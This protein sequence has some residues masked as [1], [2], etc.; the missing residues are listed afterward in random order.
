MVPILNCLPQICLI[1]DDRVSKVSNA[2]SATANDMNTQELER[3]M[4]AYQE[5][6]W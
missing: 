6:R 1:S 5:Q 2:S 3:V 4:Y